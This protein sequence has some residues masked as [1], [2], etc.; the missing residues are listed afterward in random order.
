MNIFTGIAFVFLAPL[1][2]G[3]VA[4][5]DRKISA[6]LQGRIGPPLFQPFYDV[7]KLL[8][9][10]NL[11]VRKSQRLYMEF[12]LVLIILTGAIF[13]SGGD[14]LLVIFAFTM[15]GVFFA[16]GGYKASSPYS[17]IGAQREVLQMMSYEPAVML[18]AVGMYMVTGSFQ[19]ADIVAYPQPL[20]FKLPG[21]FLAF[22]FILPIKFRKSPFDLA[23]SHHAH[24]ELVKGITTEFSGR[25]LALIEIAHWYEYI[26]VLGIGYLFFASNVWL[27]LV[28]TLVIF[29]LL[30]VVDNATARVRWQAMLGS[31]WVVA[32][33]AG[34][35]NII[36]LM[37]L[38]G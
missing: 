4:G 8:Q 31:A 28:M 29:E 11:V 38:R 22:F 19:V 3:L 2:G 20:I 25:T 27:G 34:G 14:L 35:L 32:L 15:A 10:E 9:K 1:L 30:L 36:Y 16:L 26:F 6:R 7:G 21:L 18:A 23:T 37:L 12:F 5:F 24:Q 13:F 33:I 17:F